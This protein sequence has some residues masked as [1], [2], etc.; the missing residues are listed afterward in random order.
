MHFVKSNQRQ[1][2]AVSLYRYA[3]ARTPQSLDLYRSFGD[4]GP[5][6]W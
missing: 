6:P 1:P 4:R 2:P 3:G 5:D